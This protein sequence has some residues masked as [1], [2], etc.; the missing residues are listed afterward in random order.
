M[1]LILQ[2]ADYNSYFQISTITAHP[3]GHVRELQES[4]DTYLAQCQDTYN[5]ATI[6]EVMSAFLLAA[7]VDWLINV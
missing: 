7:V 5:M 3:A 6:C 4:V 1:F 2:R